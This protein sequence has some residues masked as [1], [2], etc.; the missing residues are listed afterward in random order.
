MS[1]ENIGKES[2]M[3]ATIKL[4]AKNQLDILN[5]SKHYSK[6]L[7]NPITL[8]GMHRFVCGVRYSFF[9]HKFPSPSSCFPLFLQKPRFFFTLHSFND[10]L[11][12]GLRHV[13]YLTS[14][15]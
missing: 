12:G 5:L 11:C 9:S 6:V 2:T 3:A 1:L 14:K 8:L 13:V 10:N 7:T 4:R 15:T